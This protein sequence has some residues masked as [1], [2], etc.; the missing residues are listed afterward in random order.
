MRKRI[1][2]AAAVAAL[3]IPVMAWSK[4]PDRGQWEADRQAAFTQADANHD[5][6]LSPD[7]FATFHQIMR[8][9][10]AARMFQRADANADGSVTLDELT[11]LRGGR[12]RHGCH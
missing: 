5:G 11:A 12:G 6:A 10:L 4:A 8:Q 3:A 7:E 9:Q 2:T 1:L